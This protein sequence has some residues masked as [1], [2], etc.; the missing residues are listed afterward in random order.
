MNKLLRFEFHKILRQKSM[1]VCSVVLIC[2]SLLSL[3]TTKSLWENAGEVLG[4]V[5]GATD[6][7]VAALSSCSF[8]LILAIFTALFVSEDSSEGTI[9][10]IYSKG[11]ARAQVFLSKLIAVS[12]Y[13][14]VMAVICIAIFF[15]GGKALFPGDGALDLSGLT[16]LIPQLILMLAYTFLYTLI[17]SVSK[18][19]GDAIAGCIVVPMLASLALSIADTFL[20]M[21]AFSFSS[22]WLDNLYSAVNTTAITGSNFI[23]G[24]I[25]G[26]LYMVVLYIAG[27]YVCNKKQV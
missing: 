9:K 2:L 13:C 20:N 6:L 24:V 26:L 8:T 22:C 17:A 15:V 7:A 16:S 5:P 10:N 4:D 25:G 23:A 1:R 14:I 12:V 21:E 19:S 27:I 18:K 3:L 11:Y